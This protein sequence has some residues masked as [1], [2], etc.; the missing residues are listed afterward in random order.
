MLARGTESSRFWRG[1]TAARGRVNGLSVRPAT[2][3]GASRAGKQ[4][5]LAAANGGTLFLDEIGEMPIAARTRLLRV[6][7]ECTAIGR[8]GAETQTV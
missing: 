6:L 5:L 7:A 1:P 2:P 4:G 8:T 3:G